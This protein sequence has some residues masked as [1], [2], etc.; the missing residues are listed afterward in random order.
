M[1]GVRY[2]PAH[3]SRLLRTLGWSPQ[4][5][6][7]RATQRDEAAIATWYAERWP[8]IKKRRPGKDGPSCG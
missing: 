5:P 7:Q 6:I 4:K 3:V 2:H 8:A 1:F